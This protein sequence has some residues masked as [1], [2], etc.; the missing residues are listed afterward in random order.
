MARQ[1]RFVLPGHPQHVIHRGNNRDIIFAD[2]ADYHF[3]TEKLAHACQRYGCNIHA[4]V[5]MTNHVH[6]LITPEHKHGISQVMQSLGRYYVQYFN[7]RYRRTG[8]LWEGRYKA[9]LLQ[10]ERYLLTCYQ[11]IELNPG[12]AGM[13]ENP[14]DYPWSSYHCNALGKTDSLIVPH[15]LYCRLGESSD[16]RCRAYQSLFKE[17]ITNLTL[18][19]IREATNKAWVLGNDRF[20]TRIEQ[21]LDRQAAPKPRGG[22]RKSDGNRKAEENNRV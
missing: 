16:T 14:A 10:T 12:R 3:Y 11:Y 17:Q 13:V 2:D 18:D 5:L 19:E 8:T 21:M 1:P 15:E 9:T 22:D 6:L 7:Y 4:Y 20:K